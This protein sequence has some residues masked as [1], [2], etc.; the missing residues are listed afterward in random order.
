MNDLPEVEL[1]KAGHHGSYTATTNTLL[2][3]IR[4]KRVVVT[5]CAGHT[6]YTTNKPNT[7]PSQDFCNRV[8]PY[9]KEVYV[10][11]MAISGGYTSMN[12]NIVVASKNGVITVTGSNNST[13]LYMTAW[14]AENRTRPAAWALPK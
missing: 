1:F 12:G 2:S 14:F 4:P 8:A 7:F 6:E 10:T 11:T 13:P 5:C 9:T 3:V